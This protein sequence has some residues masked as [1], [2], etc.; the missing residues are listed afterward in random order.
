MLKNGHIKICQP[1]K[2]KR[3]NFKRRGWGRWAQAIAIG[4]VCAEKRFGYLFCFPLQGY[5]GRLS[6]AYFISLERKPIIVTVV[7]PSGVG[8]GQSQASPSEWELK[9]TPGPLA[10]PSPQLWTAMWL[11]SV[12]DRWTVILKSLLSK[13]KYSWERGNVF[14]Y[15]VSD[16]GS[17]DGSCEKVG[18]CT[19]TDNM[20]ER[21]CG[22]KFRALKFQPVGEWTH[23]CMRVCVLGEWGAK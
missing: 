5:F 19:D 2:R 9:D 7:K 12:S 11:I 3:R 15:P 8:G 20:V 13:C 14:S 6:H 10:L 23:A 22:K 21:W 4:L 18:L 1:W 16:T 17:K